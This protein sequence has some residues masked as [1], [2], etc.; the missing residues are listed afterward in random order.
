[1]KARKIISILLSL[2][3]VLSGISAFAADELLTE[4]YSTSESNAKPANFTT[5][6]AGAFS[7]KPT[8]SVETNVFGKGSTDK[9]GVINWITGASTTIKPYVRAAFSNVT[10]NG[11]INLSFNAA[12]GDKISKKAVYM[13]NANSAIDVDANVTVLM[14]TDGIYS[15]GTKLVDYDVNKWYHFDVEITGTSCTVYIDGKLAGTSTAPAAVAA[16]S[17]LIYGLYGKT[18]S[19]ADSLF[20]TDDFSVGYGAVSENR[21]TDITS[22]TY[23]IGTSIISGIGTGETVSHFLSGINGGAATLSIVDAQGA[24]VAGTE[25]LALGMQ[26]KIV[27][28]DG[29]NVRY[30]NLDCLAASIT[31]PANGSSTRD[32]TA[33]V[34]VTFNGTGSESVVFWVNGAEYETVSAAPY[35]TTINHTTGGTYTV[36]GVITAPGG[37]QQT[38]T[39]TYTFVPNAL[40]T[41]TLSGITNGGTYTATDT[42]SVTVNATDTDGTV[43][44]VALYLDGSEV[45]PVAGVYNF[46]PLSVGNHTVYAEATDNDGA[47]GTSA[48]CAFAVSNLSKVYLE[49][50]IDFTSGSGSFS[51]PGGVVGTAV[52]T[53]DGDSYG[54]YM[55]FTSTDAGDGM[56]YRQSCSYKDLASANPVY[57]ECDVKLSD[58]QMTSWVSAVRNDGVAAYIQS[59]EIASGAIGS[60]TI[61]PNRWYHYKTLVDI[62]SNEVKTWVLNDE[63]VEVLALTGSA[64]ANFEKWGMIDFIFGRSNTTGPWEAGLDNIEIY[65][66][67]DQPYLTSVEYQNSNGD[68]VL[69]DGKVGYDLS[70]IKLNFNNNLSTTL[71]QDPTLLAECVSLSQNGAEVDILTVTALDNVVVITLSN[72]VRTLAE[73]TLSY[74][75]LIDTFENIVEDGTVSFTTGPAE[76]DVLEWTI[77][78]NGTGVT[79]LSGISSGDTVDVSAKLINQSS[80][81]WEGKLIVAL[82]SGNKCLDMTVTDFSV[83][84]TPSTDK[85][86]LTLTVNPNRAIDDTVKLYAYIWSDLT[87]ARTIQ[88]QSFYME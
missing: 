60:V 70:T 53:N 79:S 72:P 50:K 64:A 22:S 67:I 81:T 8:I 55:K 59:G 2:A 4:D 14:G 57:I 61:Q 30:Y 18:E 17:Y 86:A 16:T 36:Y 62:P 76:N 82:Y 5:W 42:F 26:L 75:G 11:T 6:S 25:S 3:L 21:K 66:I 15:Y 43:E 47:K 31:G 39:I 71:T 35:T 24:A 69:A 52:V 54:E 73:H 27:S 28:A 20:Y 33:D 19:T 51:V 78:Q 74:T 40:P 45:Q 13:A 88:I 41:V 49:P 46:G 44:D 37:S 7:N 10:T 1:M 87:S 65:C 80:Q 12:A 85:D 29:V 48:S 84:T 83:G 9:S 63:G 58:T 38:D 23:T 77:K 34:T 68:N 56:T 32:L